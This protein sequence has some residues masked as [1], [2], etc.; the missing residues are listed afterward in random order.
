MSATYTSKHRV[1]LDVSATKARRVKVKKW[2]DGRHYVDLE[3]PWSQEVVKAIQTARKMLNL[4]GQG[5]SDTDD[6]IAIVNKPRQSRRRGMKK[7][8]TGQG[9]FAEDASAVKASRH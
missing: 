2:D 5:I 9:L 1:L 3:H 8:P 7:P 4:A 6:I